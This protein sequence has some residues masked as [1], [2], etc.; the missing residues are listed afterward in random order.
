MA[1]LDR[2]SGVDA[3]FLLQEGDSTHMHIGG[4]ATFAG[5]APGYDEFLDHIGSRLSLVPRYRQRV[6]EPPL[7]TGRPVWVDD[8][9]FNLG[10]HVRHTA[11]PARAGR[12][13]C[14]R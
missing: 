2:L 12:S 7:R 8:P 3:S 6:V 14:S 13:S 5:P 10:Y 1:H 11:C 4:V 9:N